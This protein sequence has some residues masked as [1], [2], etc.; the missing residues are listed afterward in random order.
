MTTKTKEK[1]EKR[2]G[3]SAKGFQPL[4]GRVLVTYAEELERTAGGIYV[5]ATAKEKPQR[6]TVQATGEDVRHV[7]VGN[8]VL[9]D[10]HSGAKTA[11]DDEEVLILKEEDILGIVVK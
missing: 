10:N 6:G 2:S 8:Q 9:F 7:K 11:I 5:P 4:G 3:T 1:R